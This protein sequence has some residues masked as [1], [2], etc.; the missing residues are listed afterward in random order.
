MSDT[1]W[2]VIAGVISISIAYGW[3]YQIG[4]K[5]GCQDTAV[6][7]ILENAEEKAREKYGNSMGKESKH[8]TS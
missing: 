7:E 2:I 4:Y 3:A 1:V 5:R 6:K 8:K